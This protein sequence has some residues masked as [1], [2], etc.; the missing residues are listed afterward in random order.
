M[1]ETEPLPGRLSR[2]GRTRVR[3]F[4]VADLNRATPRAISE[5]TLSVALDTP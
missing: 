4:P 3:A 2:Q 1:A 5:G